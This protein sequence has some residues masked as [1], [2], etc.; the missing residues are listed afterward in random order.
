M[1]I[2]IKPYSKEFFQNEKIKSFL[3]CF[4]NL[5]IEQNP[6]IAD[7]VR[8]G[9]LLYIVVVE[10]S[11]KIMAYSILSL[12]LKK[13][14]YFYFGPLILEQGIA[15]EILNLIISKLNELNVWQVKFV[16]LPISEETYNNL[17]INYFIEFNKDEFN[18]ATRLIDL[19]RPKESIENQFSENLRRNIK[20]AQANEVRTIPVTEK[21]DI[22]KI[23]HGYCDMY[24]ERGLKVNRDLTVRQFN[25]LYELLQ[26]KPEL[27]YI[28]K[29]VSSMGKILGSLVLLKQGD[30][31]FY[32]R[33]YSNKDIKLPINHIGFYDAIFKAKN[34]GYSYF[35]FGGY[36]LESQK[37]QLDGINRFKDSFGG[38]MKLYHKTIVVI[39]NKRGVFLIKTALSL[40]KFLRY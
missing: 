6:E 28:Y 24:I 13:I 4:P 31:L 8:Y 19:R 9:E 14:A 39:L 27:G 2:E 16:G 21:K 5:S 40:R 22:T 12:K 1:N 18:W 20:K 37:S 15:S 32:F 34:D 10:K 33:G 38:E 11:D 3:N 30:S 23:A 36:S 26:K 25:S 29:V 17:K 35:D 7:L